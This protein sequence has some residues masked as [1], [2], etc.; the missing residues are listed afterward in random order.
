MG[1]Q[2]DQA[3][4]KARREVGEQA[5]GGAIQRT[6]GKIVQRQYFAE[7]AMKTKPIMNFQKAS[8]EDGEIQR[9]ILNMSNIRK[10]SKQNFAERKEQHDALVAHIRSEYGDQADDLLDGMRQIQVQLKTNAELRRSVDYI[11]PRP[12]LL[13][14][15]V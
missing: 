10:E 5:F 6:A 2:G 8:A 14:F 11:S 3:A 12:L 15:C 4:S 1:Y 7:E 13:A 9:R